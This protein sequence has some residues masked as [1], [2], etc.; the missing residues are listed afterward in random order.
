[1]KLRTAD[2]DKQQIEEPSSPEGKRTIKH[3]KT[4]YPDL[5]YLNAITDFFQE[6]IKLWED[7]LKSGEI[8]RN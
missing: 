4:Q 1:M 2:E 5:S 3:T 7:C 8:S 6:N